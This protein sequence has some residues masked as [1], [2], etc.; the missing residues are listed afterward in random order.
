MEFTLSFNMDNAAFQFE[1]EQEV[2]RILLEVAEK[3]ELG[4]TRTIIRDANG[5][6]VGGWEITGD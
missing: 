4:V 5:N 6:K 1:P 3:V 2:S